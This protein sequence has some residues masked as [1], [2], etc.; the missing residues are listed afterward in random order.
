MFEKD[1]TFEK[2]LSKLGTNTFRKRKRH[3]AVANS[4]NEHP[5][6]AESITPLLF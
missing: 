2:R 1:I 5:G 4:H 6:M 3:A